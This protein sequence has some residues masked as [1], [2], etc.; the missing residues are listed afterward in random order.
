MR[1]PKRKKAKRMAVTDKPQFR[2]KSH[3]QWVR[4]HDC[5]LVNLGECDGGTEAAH[6]RSGTDGG[7]GV[8]PSD[9]WCVP[10]CRKHHAEQHA[11]GEKQFERKYQIT[12][13]AMALLMARNS[14]DGELRDAAKTRD[15]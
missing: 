11:I 12:L 7:L 4:G 6:V 13:R 1:M 15:A 5:L 8:K 10:L 14:P 3:L 9:Y 2:S